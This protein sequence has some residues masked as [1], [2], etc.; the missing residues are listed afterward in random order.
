LSRIFEGLTLKRAKK[1]ITEKLLELG[2]VSDRAELRKK[3]K[4]R[5]RGDGEA[6]GE[7]ENDGDNSDAGSST[8]SSE[9]GEPHVQEDLHICLS[10]VPRIVE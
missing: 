7:G 5:R 3:G 8:G 2:I 6:G 1:R 4:R 9:S 10:L